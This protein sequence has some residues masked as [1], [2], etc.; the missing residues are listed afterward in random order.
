MRVMDLPRGDCS[1][2]PRTT[3]SEIAIPFEASAV[4]NSRKSWKRISYQYPDSCN[5]EINSSGSISTSGRFP[6]RFARNKAAKYRKKKIS[7]CVFFYNA[8][9]MISDNLRR[10]ITRD[11]FDAVM[12]F[13]RRK[14]AVGFKYNQSEIFYVPSSFPYS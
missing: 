13:T 12:S 8:K 4:T 2:G 9:L 11:K 10:R 6:L 3:S 5:L 7:K 14:F 1:F